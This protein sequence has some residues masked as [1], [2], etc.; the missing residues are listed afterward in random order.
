MSSTANLRVAV[1]LSTKARRMLLGEAAA[2]RL[3]EH[4]DVVWAVGEPDEWD[5]EQLIDG[6]DAALT[7]WWTPPLSRELIESHPSLGFIGHTAGSVR[8]LIPLDLIGQRLRVS[9]ATQF[10]APSVSEFTILH[11]LSA[12]RHLP[13]LDHELKSGAP[14]DSFEDRYTPGLIQGRT[15]GVVG[16]S[17]SGQAVVRLLRAFGA[18][19]LVVDPTV[20]AETI[21]TLGAEPVADLDELF[22]RSDIVTLHAPLLTETEGMVGAHELALLR[23][24]GIFVNCARGGLVDD[25]ALFAEVSSGRISASLDVFAEEPLPLDDRWR[26]LT[27]VT[28][29][30]HRAGFTV[31]AL[32]QNGDA[33]IDD[34]IRWRDAKPLHFEL[35]ADRVSVIA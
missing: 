28:I 29:S 10:F 4:A 34:L 32:L 11:I 7:G 9:Q 17:R 16:A 27:N 33:M 30:P 23:D 35:P 8:G 25:D 26:T 15:V 6:A 22:Q 19:V 1:L 18:D 20:P 13:S 24:G 12:L 3:M 21:R 2:Q 5:L 31:E 14:F